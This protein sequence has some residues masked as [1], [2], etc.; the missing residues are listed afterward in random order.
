MSDAFSPR[1]QNTCAQNGA[2][3]DMTDVVRGGAI[4]PSDSRVKQRMAFKWPR[5]HTCKRPAIDG[6]RERD[7]EVGAGEENEAVVGTRVAR[8]SL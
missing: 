7:M 1:G 8:V 2:K 5:L 3:L 4:S 6:Q